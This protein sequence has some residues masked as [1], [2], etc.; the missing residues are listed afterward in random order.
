MCLPREDFELEKVEQQLQAQ[1]L[2]DQIIMYL[3]SKAE[4][5]TNV[6]EKIRLMRTS[7]NMVRSTASPILSERV[8]ACLTA[9]LVWFH[10]LSFYI[11][12]RK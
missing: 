5:E 12:Q 4:Q 2:L 9:V 1:T 6:V 10:G 3:R 8:Q 7:S 11:S